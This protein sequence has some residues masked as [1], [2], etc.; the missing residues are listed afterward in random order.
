MNKSRAAIFTLAYSLQLY[1]K[2]YATMHNKLRFHFAKIV[3]FYFEALLVEL[4]C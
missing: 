3:T 2:Y 1:L 4:V